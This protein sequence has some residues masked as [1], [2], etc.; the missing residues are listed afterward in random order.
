[1]HEDEKAMLM[2][3]GG[4]GLGQITKT[5]ENPPLIRTIDDLRRAQDIARDRLEELA[6]RLEPLLAA[7]VPEPCGGEQVGRP[8]ASPLDSMLM[9]RVGSAQAMDGRIGNLLRRLSI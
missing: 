1:M 5:Q 2:R 4:A 3:S 8:S 7:P 6:N 9:E